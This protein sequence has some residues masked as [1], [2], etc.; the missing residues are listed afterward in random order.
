MAKVPPLTFPVRGTPGGW[1]DAW[2]EDDSAQLHAAAEAFDQRL[3]MDVQSIG[4]DWRREIEAEQRA[5]ARERDRERR[6]HRPAR[7]AYEQ[8]FNPRKADP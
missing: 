8:M 2:D 7:L 3:V 1:R 6:R 4:R 5:L